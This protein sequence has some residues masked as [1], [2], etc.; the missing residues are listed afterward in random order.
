M[1]RPHR[2]FID[3]F[4]QPIWARTV[5]ELREKVGA[6]R[7]FKVYCDKKEGPPMHVGYGVGSRWFN[8]YAPVERPI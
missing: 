7:V 1:K 8:E 4:G 3:Q 6:G 5:K 2:L